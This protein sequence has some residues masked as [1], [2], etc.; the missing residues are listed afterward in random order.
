MLYATYHLVTDTA[1]KNNGLPGYVDVLGGIVDAILVVN[2]LV[3]LGI[4]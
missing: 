1:M 3:W 4:L 2:A